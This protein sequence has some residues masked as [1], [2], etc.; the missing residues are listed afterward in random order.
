MTY[1]VRFR[2]LDSDNVTLD[3]LLD[4][5]SEIDLDDAIS[6]RNPAQ[7]IKMAH[8]QAIENKLLAWTPADPGK[9]TQVYSNPNQE[10][11]QHSLPRFFIH[12]IMIYS[13]CGAKISTH[14]SR[15][16][17]ITGSVFLG[18]CRTLTHTGHLKRKKTQFVNCK[19]QESQALPIG[20]TEDWLA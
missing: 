10:H 14:T 9:I 13:R 11:E 18:A 7:V 19:T 4:A 17:I 1:A 8:Q 15:P 16:A 6:D 5:A 12:L 3:E 20:C 2:E